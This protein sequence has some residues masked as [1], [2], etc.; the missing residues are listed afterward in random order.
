MSWNGFPNTVKYIL[1]KMWIRLLYFGG[2]GE[3]L[4]KSHIMESSSKVQELSRSNIRQITCPGWNKRY[5]GKTDRCFYACLPENSS[6]NNTSA[7]GQHFLRCERLHYDQLNNVT[8]SS[9]F[10]SSIKYLIF[11]PSRREHIFLCTTRQR[12]FATYSDVGSGFIS[13]VSTVHNFFCWIGKRVF[14][15]AFAVFVHEQ[16]SLSQKTC[17]RK[18]V[19]VY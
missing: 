10:S 12:K 13:F 2:R 16:L 14:N 7:I 6:Q 17:H 5:L 9:N 11:K 15:I 8:F 4:L 1:P 18:Y 19:C 3:N